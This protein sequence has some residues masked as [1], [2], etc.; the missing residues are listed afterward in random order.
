MREAELA[1]IMRGIAPVLKE[2]VSRSVSDVRAQ[3]DVREQI[4]GLEQSVKALAEQLSQRSA[5]V[6]LKADPAQED[7]EAYRFISALHTKAI[8]SGL[9][10]A[11]EPE[12]PQLMAVRARRT[13][14]TIRYE[15]IDGHKRPVEIIQDEG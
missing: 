5:V 6:E 15:E 2:Y 3:L 8:L 14:K 11:D 4:G 7:D 9:M 13:V 10:D 12:P 1:A